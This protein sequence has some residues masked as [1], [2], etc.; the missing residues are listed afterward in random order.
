[1]VSYLNKSLSAAQIEEC[2]RIANYLA[3][4]FGSA[5]YTLINYGVEG[6]D[7][8][9]GKDGPTYTTTGQKEANEDTYQFLAAGQNVWNN[10]GFPGI[11]Q[12]A[13]A[14]SADAVKYAYKPLFSDFNVTVPNRFATAASAAELTDV[15]TQISYGTKTIS[16]YQAAVKSWK[17]SGGNALRDWYQ[18]NVYDKYG[19][20]Q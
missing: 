18:K 3:A 6:T 13:C 10:P 5:E 7:W 9:M 4:P 2:L 17:S 14:W 20:G 19:A 11:T 15:G 12:I 16:D 1:M 8:T